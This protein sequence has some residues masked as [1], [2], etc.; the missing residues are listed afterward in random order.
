[1][2]SNLKKVLIVWLAVLMMMLTG[3]SVLSADYQAET[4]TLS[5]GAVVEG[6]YVKMTGSGGKITFTGLPSTA[7]TVAVH[8]RT[9]ANAG[10]NLSFN[11]QWNAAI[12]NST[13]D[14]SMNDPKGSYS[15]TTYYIS[16]NSINHGQTIWIDK[17]SDGTSGGGDT[18]APVVSLTAPANGATVSD[19]VTVSATASDDIRVTRVEFYH[20][21]TLIA[22]DTTSP[23]SVSWDTTAVANGTYSLTAKAY[24]AANNV[25]TSAARSVTVSNTPTSGLTVHF[26]NNS[27]TNWSTFNCYYWGSNGSPTANSWP[28]QTMTPEGNGWYYFVIPGAT[29]SNVIFD[30]GSAQTVDLSRT[31]EGW[32]VPAGTSGGKINGTWYNSNPDVGGD[33]TAPTVSLSAPANGATVSGSVTVSATASD[34]VGVTKV[35]F[36]H[37]TTLIAS[38]T[39]SPYSISW[40]TAGVANDSYNLMAKAYDAANNVGTSALVNV[41]VSNTTASGLTV[42]FKRPS[43]WGTSVRIHYWNMVPSTIPNSGAWPG[44]LMTSEGNDW[45]KCTVAIATGMNIV[46]N[47][48]SGHQTTDL[49]RS[50][51]EGWYYTDNQWY[52]VNPEAPAPPVISVNVNGSRPYMG[53]TV[54]QI[55][56]TPKNTPVTSKSATFNGNSITFGGEAAQFTLATYLSDLATGTLN[57]TAASSAGTSAKTVQITRDDSYQTSSG[58]F[59]WD[60]ALVY[61]VITD[62][63]FNGNISNDEPYGRRKDYGSPLLNTGTYHGGD[64]AGLTQKLESGY[65]TDLG[66]NTIWISAVYEQTHGWCGGGSGGDFSHYPYHGY[67]ALDWTAM[68]QNMGTIEEMRTFV[69]TA[70]SLGIRVIMDV[71]LNHTGYN[72]ILDMNK[73]N[74]GE[75]N[76]TVLAD[77]WTPSS[78]QTWHSY[79]NYITYNGCTNPT[80]WQNWWGIGWVRT[81][82]DGYTTGNGSELQLALAGLP[83]LR[84][85][86]ISSQGLPTIL[87]TKWAM[88]T[89]GYSNWINPSAVNL[90]QDLGIAPADYVIR[91]LAA[92]VREF[93]IDGFRCDTAKHVELNRWNQLKSS[94]VTALQEW[95]SANPTKPGASWTEPFWMTGESWDYGVGDSEYFDNGFDSMIN[96]T[97]PNKAGNTDSVGATW[98]GYADAINS[99]PTWNVLTYISSHDTA[100][101]AIGNKINA[102]TCLVL[103]PGGVQ[104]FYG[105]ENDRPLGPVCSDPAQRTRSDYVWNANPNVLV[106]WQKLGRFR[107]MHPAVGAGSQ[108][109]L[110]NDTYGRIWNDDKI[111]IKINGSGSTEVSVNGIFN[112]GASVRNAYN[113]ETGIVNGG[114]VTFTAENGVILIEQI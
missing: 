101:Y 34:N 95:R 110:G 66:V 9:T 22:S 80:L 57:V 65:F 58:V 98:Q 93:G 102:G 29:S 18:T 5:G 96:F 48:G 56:V 74:F 3:Q 67:Y 72:T 46:F 90:R 103:C 59:T 28:G 38:D 61:F 114:K 37:G 112:D 15:K 64:L 35:E 31:G 44:I 62:R 109:S 100:L 60:N 24:D 47:D 33:S 7:T 84:T 21:T 54:I 42:H 8:Y 68:D 23:Y 13:S 94:C 82:I 76:Q 41:N 91:W 87:R 17:I 75:Y 73:Y 106:H 111:V 11:G 99:D 26:K 16:L 52:D 19:S 69:D 107:N 2:L 81:G 6:N 85:E 40:N 4:A 71:V 43:T 108:I 89:S 63:F 86:L 1:V 25:G 50:S 79:H 92:W 77:S 78:G 97:F 20:W 27:M 14:T 53:S 36:Y 39:T 49:S 30:N 113:G 105:D 12:A 10:V 83:D 32:W 45:Y 51:T 104:I 55:T 70:H 88:E